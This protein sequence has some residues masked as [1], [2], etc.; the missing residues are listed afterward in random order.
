MRQCKLKL[1]FA[2]TQGG[3]ITSPKQLKNHTC[4]NITQ[5]HFSPFYHYWGRGKEGGGKALIACNLQFTT[6]LCLS[7]WWTGLG[8]ANTAQTLLSSTFCLCFGAWSFEKEVSGELKIVN[9][10]MSQCFSPWMS[11][12]HR[13]EVHKILEEVKTGKKSAFWF[14]WITELGDN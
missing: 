13:D 10:M 4:I 9:I 6:K 14:E 7:E 8:E 5:E 3:V 12:N 2:I 11:L 1:P